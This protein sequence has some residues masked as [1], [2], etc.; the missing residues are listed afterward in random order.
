M[1]A[2]KEVKV[3]SYIT[4]SKLPDAD[5]VINPYIG[6]PHA[7]I[8]CYAEFMK[9][10]TNHSEP[11]GEFL[12]IK[13]GDLSINKKLSEEDVILF[14]SVTDAYN[15]YEQKY[16]LTQKL[17]MQ[18]INSP[19]HI[20]ILT[21][22]DLVL[23]DIKIIK[24]IPNIRVGIS[25]N[26]L[27]D[28]FRKLIEPRASS[29]DKR[30]QALNELN[31]EGIDTYVFISPIFPGIT[32]FREIIDASLSFTKAYYFENLNL[33]GSFYPRVLAFITELYPKLIFLYE[34]IY[35]NKDYFY[36][37]DLSKDI[38]NFCLDRQ[39]IHKIYFYH[40]KIKKNS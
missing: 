8:Y 15:P 1:I 11:W 36:W 3:K 6:C 32:D 33:R 21:K 7:C 17:L 10:F 22:S 37:E 25:M 39:L 28:D 23:R 9:R 26:T 12:D 38:E 24:Q 16:C 34:K 31:K 30:L 20:E 4:K 27:D 13:I 40:T 5:Y 29:V 2:I 35:K 18:F 19:A 14:G